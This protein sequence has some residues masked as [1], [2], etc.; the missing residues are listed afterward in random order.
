MMPRAR[1][2]FLRI[3]LLMVLLVGSYIILQEP[4][5]RAETR[6]SAWVLREANFRVGQVRGTGVYVAPSGQVPFYAV[7]TPSCSALASV[8][9]LA[10]L[11]TVVPATSRRRKLVALGAAV[12]TVTLGNIIRITASLAVGLVLGRGSLVL[13]HDSVGNVFS[14]AYTLGGYILMLYILLPAGRAARLLSTSSAPRTLASV[15]S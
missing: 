15:P 2:V 12:L 10:F 14:F 4:A 1:A 11:A 3:A 7:V 6:T 13:F 8:L 5:R 9:A